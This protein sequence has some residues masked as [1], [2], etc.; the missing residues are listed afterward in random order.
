MPSTADAVIIGAGA[1]GCSTAYHLARLGVTNV[2]VVEM[3]QVGSGSSSKSASMLSLQFYSSELGARMAQYSYARYMQFEEEIGVPIDFKK[4]GWVS[5]A[6]RESAER[7]RQSAQVLQS[8]GIRT[9]LL[10]PEEVKHRYPEINT[11]DI[12]L[13]AWGPDDGPFD[14]HMIMWGYINRAHEMGVRLHQ[15]VRATGVRVRNGR[16]EGVMTDEGFV[17]APVVVNAGGPWA[18]EIGSWVGVEI[19]ITNSARSIVVTGPFP[20]IPSTWPFIEDVTAEWYC[21]PEGPGILMGMGASPTDELDIPFR[22]D[23]LDEMID[24]AAH[25]VPIL[26][27]ASFMTGWTGVRPLTRDDLPIL[28]PA[29]AVDGFV[30]NCGWG[31]AGII[32]APIAGQLVAEYISDGYTSTMDIGPLGI[33]RFQ[34][35]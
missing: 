1:I 10:T 22:M 26:M 33:E 4:T 19:P 27:S 28:G 31:G 5:L 2:L 24:T 7:L 25:R 29:P 3:G 15:G 32:Q 23:V 9:E 18:I 14:P 13:G 21:R 17:A 11:A 20:D 34:D 30:L 16:V 8:L 6:T 12:V 35:K